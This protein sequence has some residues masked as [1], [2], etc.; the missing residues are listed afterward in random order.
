MPDE[1]VQLVA[2][3]AE[4]RAGRLDSA[5]D[6]CRRLVAMSPND[7]AAHQLAATIALQ[8][9]KLSEAA[10]WTRSCLVLRPDHPPSLTLSG[11]IAR[12]SGDPTHAVLNFR[13]ASELA[14]GRPEALFLLCAALLEQGKPEAQEL[15]KQLFQR[16]PDYA[17]GWQEIGAVLRNA[18]QI[19]AAAA[20]FARAANGSKEPGHQLRLAVTLQSLGRLAE[21]IAA[22]HKALEAAPDHLEARLLLASCLRQGG[23]PRLARIE[24]ESATSLERE[25]SRAWFSLGVVCD[26][27]QDIPGAIAAYRKCIDL[28]PD[29]PEALVNLGLSLQNTGDLTGALAAY[30]RAVQLRAD[31]FGRI[32]QGLSAARTGQLWLDLKKLRRSLTS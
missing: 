14:P 30:R 32:A 26:D 9:G 22:L 21:A 16:F 3:L 29:S 13:R 18:G 25:S 24:L 28:Q 20:A 5:E 6:L 12:A 4:L 23:E 8:R 19:E 27:L 7:A 2:A 11:R 1:P 17:D 10:R 15:L 31:T